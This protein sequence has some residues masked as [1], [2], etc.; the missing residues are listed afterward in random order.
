MSTP[1][2]T[3]LNLVGMVYD[4][5]LDQRK[6][7]TFLDAFAGAVGGCSAMLRSADL[8]TGKAEFVSSVGYD[9]AWQSA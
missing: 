8:Q 5:A 9:P 4:A 1:E 7:P 3:A 2:D 6:W